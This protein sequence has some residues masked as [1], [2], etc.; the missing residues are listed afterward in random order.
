LLLEWDISGARRGWGDGDLV[1][2]DLDLWGR[3]RGKWR[4]LNERC[5]FHL[6]FTSLWFSNVKECGVDGE[7]VKAFGSAKAEGWES[8]TLGLE[9]LHLD[10]EDMW[11]ASSGIGGID[12]EWIWQVLGCDIDNGGGG[13]IG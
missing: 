1:D 10:I 7:G 4:R 13:W 11:I 12:M 2:L 9:D 5:I 8:Q 6:N 3:H